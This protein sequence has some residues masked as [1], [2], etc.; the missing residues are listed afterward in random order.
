[1]SPYWGASGNSKLTSF[2]LRCFSS[3]D[4][5][6]HDIQKPCETRAIRQRS[7]THASVNLNYSYCR[8]DTK[9]IRQA[10]PRHSPPLWR[11]FCN[12]QLLEKPSVIRLVEPKFVTGTRVDPIR[13]ARS[14][15]SY[16]EQRLF[17]SIHRNMNLA[18]ALAQG[19]PRN[20]R[21]PFRGAG[22]HGIRGST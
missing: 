20:S 17:T 10:G 6:A 14:L 4:N 3:P 12:D 19:V 5:G 8:A 2:R 21:P 22:R 7:M 9:Q 15:P 13:I 1:M 11:C 16:G 18:G